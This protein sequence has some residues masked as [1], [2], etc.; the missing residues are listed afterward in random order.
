M[1][2]TF[3]LIFLYIP[4]LSFSQPD[5]YSI[6]HYSVAD[7]LANNYIAKI[8]QDKYGLIWVAALTDIS[9]F[10]AHTFHSLPP[11][12]RVVENIVEDYLGRLWLDTNGAGLD[13]VE[14]LQNRRTN[15]DTIQNEKIRLG[16]LG[17]IYC[18]ELNSGKDYLWMGSNA[19]LIKVNLRTKM[20]KRDKRLMNKTIS[21]IEAINDSLLWLGTHESGIWQLNLHSGAL[22]NLHFQSPLLN[23]AAIREMYRKSD[24]VWV[25]T[26]EDGLFHI[27]LN[28]GLVESIKY[29][30]QKIKANC[31]EKSLYQREL[32]LGTSD[33]LLLLDV[34]TKQIKP[35]LF[36]DYS[37][38]SSG[39]RSIQSI[40]IDQ[41]KKIMWVGTE[42]GLFKVSRN[43]RPFHNIK[44]IKN[45][46]KALINVTD[47][48]E[49]ADQKLLVCSSSGLLEW[50]GEQL[51]QAYP[52]YFV[53]RVITKANDSPNS[54][55]VGTYYQGLHKW[56]HQQ[57]KIVR[58]FQHYPNDSSSLRNANAIYTILARSNQVFAPSFYGGVNRLNL[59]NGKFE[60]PSFFF[61][62]TNLQLTLK[63][64]E[65]KQN[66]GV[67]FITLL[68]PVFWDYEKDE[69]IIPQLFPGKQVYNYH[70]YTGYLD[71]N[72][73]L[74]IG[75]NQGI[76]RIAAADI[77]KVKKNA[78][79]PYRFWNTD[80]SNLAHSVIYNIL[81]DDQKRIWC[82]TLSGISCFEVDRNLFYNFNRHNGLPFNNINYN[83]SLKA[84]DGT[85]YFGGD[86][87]F[88]YFHPDD[89]QFTMPENKLLFQDIK[90]NNLS[91]LGQA[92][93]PYALQDNRVALNLS[94]K[95]NFLEFH[96]I[97]LNY[98][99]PGV[100]HYMYRLDGLEANWINGYQS[101]VV[102][103][104]NLPPG[105]YTFMVTSK[106]DQS[107]KNV[108]KRSFI[109]RP[110]F[111]RRWWFYVSCGFVLGAMVYGIY[112]NRMTQIKEIQ[113]IRNKISQDLHDDIGASVS[114]I[115]ILA[116]LIEQKTDKKQPAYVMVKRIQDQSKEIGDALNDI[117]WSINPFNDKLDQLV[118]RMR[119][120]ASALFEA[121]HINGQLLFEEHLE[122]IVLGM[123]QRRQLW[124]IYKEAINNLIKHADCDTAKVEFQKVGAH[125]LRLVIEDNGKGFD[126]SRN[127]NG[128][129]LRNLHERAKALQ[130]E[131]VLTSQPNHGTTIELSFYFTA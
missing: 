82:S 24:D 71:S 13:Y 119:R 3:F 96:Y 6:R 36:Y 41:H 84:T 95:Q 63:I 100:A 105:K 8:L 19:G 47:F 121:K 2:K 43:P 86:H 97:A 83:A 60:H 61:N 90:I 32:L 125:K 126:P 7:G 29:N 67:W 27:G 78:P 91:I 38:Y 99:N 44:H 55:W 102:R 35:Y 37:Q 48:A 39:E 66:K 115:R 65:D 5:L 70:F 56:D 52:E 40:L 68:G 45:Q 17:E 30:G 103:Y 80:N 94:H 34:V 106:N 108:L 120:Y 74:W 22:N 31:I 77:H 15:L 69:Y 93:I 107:F 16:S 1:K 118:A 62:E 75:T 73:Y 25:A 128:N 131:L 10:D 57:K 112:L 28:T 49:T 98:A 104:S 72:Q 110:P 23:R 21:S 87:G 51:I 46:T 64:I 26:F 92:A 114:S 129:G 50:N 117:I 116:T 111:W 4:I 59:K 127:Q 12:Q 18:M 79:F 109:I 53:P 42:G 88:I 130:A 11:K 20:V 101:R 14:L 81:E 33:G 113:G 123:E 76:L 85:M 124:L 54:Y 122:H 58:S 89:I 9:Y